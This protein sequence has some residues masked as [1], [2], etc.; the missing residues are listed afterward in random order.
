VVRKGLIVSVYED[1][2]NL[3]VIYGKDLGK[4]LES[5]AGLREKGERRLNYI[6]G[7]EDNSEHLFRGLAVTLRHPR[8][9]LHLRYRSANWD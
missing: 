8:A 2:L 6:D 4:I 1:A 7:V 3:T 9:P 5:R